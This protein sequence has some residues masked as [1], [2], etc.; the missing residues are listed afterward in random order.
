MAARKSLSWTACATRGE[1]AQTGQSLAGSASG[2]DPFGAFLRHCP[3]SPGTGGPLSDLR[4]AVKDNI[5]VKGQPFTAGLPL[6]A[7][8]IADTD[9]VSV[10]RLLKAG[11]RFVGVTRTDAGGFGVT[12]PDVLNPVF[13][14]HIV[15]GSSGGSAAA[16]A[17][18]LAEIGLGTDTGGSVRI[19]AACSALLGF[20]PTHD[21]IPRDG[22]WP[23]APSFDTV[24]LI[25]RDFASL[26]R[27]AALLLKLPARKDIAP[28]TLRIGVDYGRLAS[29]EPAVVTATEQAL[30]RLA[31][32]GVTLQPVTLPDRDAT[33]QIH[34]TRV[35]SESYALYKDWSD[36]LELLPGLVRHAIRGA[37]AQTADAVTAA[38]LAGDA[39]I[40]EFNACCAGLDA[41]I[42]PTLPILPPPAGTRRMTFNGRE[43]SII[44]VLVAETCLANITG[45]PALSIPLGGT[46]GPGTS[47]QLMARRGHDDHLLAIVQRLEPILRG[48]SRRCSKRR[49]MHDT[50][51]I[52]HAAFCSTQILPRDKPRFAPPIVLT[53]RQ[54]SQIICVQTNSRKRDT[55]AVFVLMGMTATLREVSMSPRARRGTM[56]PHLIRSEARRPAIRLPVILGERG[57]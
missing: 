25:A 3:D 19:P 35:L 52:M 7:N 14:G 8:R 20:K 11:A 55:G 32:G 40:V 37:Q 4:L 27:A 49:H 48:C 36:K 21:R 12:A 26:K 16:V 39:V 29:C 13:P 2:P 30:S 44:S 45:G 5:A 41:I 18:G 17:A 9:A 46:H 22:T 56:T 31:A 33:L 6:F 50:N 51:F 38:Q 28:K 10:R 1:M 47:L 54:E 15:G 34:A 24:G 53:S 57:V 43:Q 23:L 42:T